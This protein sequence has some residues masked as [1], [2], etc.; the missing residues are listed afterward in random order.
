[1]RSSYGIPYDSPAAERH[2]I[3]AS[4][5]PFGNRS[6][7]VDPA[8]GFD[9][10]YGGKNPHPIV[11]DRNTQYVPFGAFGATDPN[12]NSP[13][14]Q[15]WNVTIERELGKNYGASVSYLGSHS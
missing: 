11:T 7:I 14:I 2:N 5:P 8:G 6:L 13:R 10:P 9:D 12:I 15:S 1:M 4:A 3:N